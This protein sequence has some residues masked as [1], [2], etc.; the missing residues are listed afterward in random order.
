MS[1]AFK[2]DEVASAALGLLSC[3]SVLGATVYRDA[4]AEFVGG[5]GSVVG[6]RLPKQRTAKN[7]TGTT[8]YVDV[9]EGIAHIKLTD[10]PTDAAKLG[11]RDMSLDIRDFGAQVL[12]PQMDSVSR[13]IEANIASLMNAQSEK[14]DA[15]EID[16]ATPLKALSFAAAEFVRR[17]VDPGDRFLAVGPSVYGA[18]LDVEQLQRVNEAGDD[19]MLSHAEMGTLFGF[20]VIVS[21]HITGAVAYHRNAFALA[22]RAPNANEG[23]GKSSSQTFNGYAI[24]ATLDYSAD[25]KSDVSIVDSLCGSA[26][27]DPNRMIAFKLK[28]S[29]NK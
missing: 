1:N 4:E 9:E 16:P 2:I 21:P 13:Y 10:E 29:K 12:M 3:Q 11:T 24:R 22:N 17:Q 23:A 27:L 25:V 19:T 20:R 6:V 14:A 8:E 5:R 15:I 18:L 28:Q 26:I 7:Y